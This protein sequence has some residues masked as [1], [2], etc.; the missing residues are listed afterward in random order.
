M[1]TVIRDPEVLSRY[2]RDVSVVQG[3]P[4]GVVRPTEVD[5]VEQIVGL[6]AK[7]GTP[8]LAVG[9][10]TSTTGASVAT[11]G[12]VVVDMTALGT[13]AQVDPQT[14]TLRAQPGAV[15]ADLH[16]LARQHGFDMP[17]DPTSSPDCTIG[18]AVATNA[19]GPSSFRHGA[20]ADW[21]VGLEFV[22]GL[23]QRRRLRSP[24]VPKRAMGPAALQDAPRW[25]VGSEGTLGML[26]E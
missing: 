14:A 26:T 17:V 4:D 19:S 22:D 23:G 6:C 9:A 1:S 24:G 13:D 8:V 5:Q 2:E 15:L 12:G 10:R 25:F 20:I 11:D 18:G 21:V 16:L 7:E 3:R